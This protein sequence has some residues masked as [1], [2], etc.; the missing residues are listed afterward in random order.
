MWAWSSSVADYAAAASW[1][2]SYAELAPP[3]AVDPEFWQEREFLT[4]DRQ[5]LDTEPP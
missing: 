2:R 4:G 1:R 5:H 3:T